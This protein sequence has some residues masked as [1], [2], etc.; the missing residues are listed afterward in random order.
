MVFDFSDRGKG[1]LDDVAIRA[2]NLHA[3]SRQGLRSFHASHNASDA[4]SVE[5]DNLDVVFAIERLESGESLGDFHSCY[6]PFRSSS[7]PRH[8][9]SAKRFAILLLSRSDVHSSL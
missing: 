1:Y 6:F 4:T 2:F 8:M 7:A 5:R 3:R 9:N